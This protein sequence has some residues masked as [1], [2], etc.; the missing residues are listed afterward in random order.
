MFTQTCILSIPIPATQ[1]PAA[2]SI[3]LRDLPD[4]AIEATAQFAERRRKPLDPRA[5]KE[6]RRRRKTGLNRLDAP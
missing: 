1:S 6:Y 4:F 5:G 3:T 2:P